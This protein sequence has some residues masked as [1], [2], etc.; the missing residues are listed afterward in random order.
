MGKMTLK[1]RILIL[2]ADYCTLVEWQL[3]VMEMEQSLANL[4]VSLYTCTVY[5]VQCNFLS[6]I[7]TNKRMI[8]LC[9]PSYINC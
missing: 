8:Y 9:F 1:T 3:Y 5:S 7:K 6:T 2:Q 4:S